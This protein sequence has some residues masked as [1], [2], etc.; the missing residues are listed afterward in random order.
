MLAIIPAR[1]GSKG[2]P[3]KNIRLL[4]GKPLIH[5]TIEAA[6]KCKSIDRVILSTDSQ[7]IA[8]A[9]SNI[10]IEIPFMRPANLA[11]DGS[12]AVDVYNYTINRLIQDNHF[13]DDK[14]VVLLPTVPFVTSNDIDNAVTIF[15]ENNADSV[16]SCTRLPFPKEWI[17][18]VDT[19]TNLIKNSNNDISLL[20]R[21]N[22]K[23][24]FIANGGIYILRH[25]LISTQK[26]YYFQNTMAYEMPEERS[27]DIDT[28]HDFKLAEFIYQD[29]IK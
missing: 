10:G 27:I 28:I 21:Q 2:L 3:G 18:D 15:E 9:C 14:Y 12:Y 24:S 19:K 5:W 7:E 11:E 22:Y 6:L 20:P 29:S 4:G 1:G 13:S 25:S 23:N 8:D 26:T 16:I 17:F